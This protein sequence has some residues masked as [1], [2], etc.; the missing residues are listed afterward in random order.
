MDRSF[1][2][3]FAASFLIEIAALVM[4]IRAVARDQF[5]GLAAARMIFHPRE[6]GVVE[7]PARAAAEHALPDDL[8]YQTELAHRAVAD[9]S[10]KWPVLA[11]LVSA[12]VWL[13]L[14]SIFGL[15]T[16]LK[17]NL[18]DFLAADAAL[19]FGRLRP[20][21]LNL[22]AYGWLSM[23][24]VAVSLWLIPRLVRHPLVG[25]TWAVA[26]AIFWNV[27]VTAGFLA[28]LGGWTEGIEWLEFPLQ[29]DDLL[30][31][32]GALAG[33]PLILTIRAS[34]ARHL[35][36]SVWY[37]IAAFLWFPFLFL[38]ANAPGVHFGVEQA[39]ANWWFAHNV[40]GLWFTP[41]SLAAAYYLIPKIIGRPIHSYGLSLLGFWGLALFYSHVGIHHL[42]GGPV[43]TW[44]VTVSTVSSMMMF[45]PVIAV[46]VNHHFTMRGHFS[47]LRDSPTLKFIVAGAMAY[48]LTS[49]QGSLQALRTVNQTTHFTH[50]TVAHAHFGAYGFASLILFGASYFL[51]PRLLGR[52]WPRPAWINVHFW[53]SM[54]GILLYFVGLSIGG[55]LQGRAMLDGSVPFEQSVTVT[56]PYLWSRTVAGTIMTLA[57]LVY[58]VHVAWMVFGR[59]PAAALRANLSEVA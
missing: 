37:I 13:N 2:I 14:G 20:V 59:A 21:H 25:G 6:F 39:A 43:P 1:A 55:W 57:H 34:G 40:L 30:V 10:S 19:T 54:V 35:Y 45:V 24:G 23:A 58:A 49:G 8:D 16:A 44:L 32:G 33:I 31:V 12:V 56:L 9:R 4:L 36:V 29:I 42:I 27:G 48:T 28:L 22:V 17:F 46:A 38:V 11:F 15:L 50:F 26:G 53:L 52:E 3:L 47:V 5:G 7:D 18:P 51:L 41:I